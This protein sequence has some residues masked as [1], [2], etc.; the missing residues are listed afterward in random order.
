MKIEQVIYIIESPFSKRDMHRFG[1]DIFKKYGCSVIVLDLTAYL[2]K[3]VYL[4]YVRNDDSS[5]SFVKEIR[6]FKDIKKF[7]LSTHKNTIFISFI[8][9]S[10]IKSVKVLNFLSKTNKEFGIILSGLLPSPCSMQT[11]FLNKLK[12]FTLKRI[13]KSFTNKMY[14]ILLNKFIYSF[15]IV[16][17]KKSYEVL[18]NC[19]YSKIVHGHAFDY[20]LFLENEKNEKIL[21]QNEYIVFLD[22]FFPFHPDYIG[23]GLDYSIYAKEYYLKLSNYFNIIEEKLNLKV[24]I[25]AHPRSYYDSLPDYWNGRKCIRGNTINLVKNSKLCLLHASTSINYAVL[26]EKPIVF[27][28]MEEI[29]KSNVQSTLLAMA[30]ELEAKVIDV[31]NLPINYIVNTEVD[32]ILYEKYI[33]KYIKDSNTKSINNWEIL[34]ESYS[35]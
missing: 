24:I 3:N 13:V 9:N 7:I 23:M 2:D 18:K 30:E 10:S 21:I 4:N 16:S 28:T 15:I 12:E 5:F 27:L 1:V 8:G 25:C 6:S 32:K 29:K 19:K 11:S 33:Y 34:Y 35:L 22:E 14:K 31:D 26:Y 17:G 20:D